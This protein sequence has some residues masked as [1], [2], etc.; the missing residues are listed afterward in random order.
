MRFTN[1]VEAHTLSIST[2]GAQEGE[3]SNRLLYFKP[4]VRQRQRLVKRHVC[5]VH[6]CY[7]IYARAEQ[8]SWWKSEQEY[9]AQM[10]ISWNHNRD[11]L[12]TLG[13]DA[14]FSVIELCV[15][16]VMRRMDCEL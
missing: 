5:A 15:L 3:M 9:L 8:V 7:V 13:G 16:D 2:I 1:F 11:V 6:V 4:A 12:L 14:L 10:K